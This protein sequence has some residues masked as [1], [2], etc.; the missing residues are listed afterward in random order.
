MKKFLF[1]AMACVVA[2]VANVN[3]QESTETLDEVVVKTNPF[4]TNWFIQAGVGL[5]YFEGDFA[6]DINLG[7]KISPNV[8]LEIG[9]WF[10]P[11]VGLRAG[12]RGYELTT[13]SSQK[14]EFSSSSTDNEGRFTETYEVSNLHVDFLLNLSSVICG[15]KEDHFYKCVPYVGFGVMQ[16]YSGYWDNDLAVSAGLLNSF[17]L[18][19]AFDLNLDIAYTSFANEYSFMGRTS[20]Y[21]L[22]ATVGLTY[23]FKKRGWEG[24]KATFTGISEDDFARINDQLAAEKAKNSA[25]E[26]DLNDQKVLTSAAAA[27]AAAAEAKAAA[28]EAKIVDPNAQLLVTFAIAATKL[29][30]LSLVNIEYYANTIKESNDGDEFVLTGYADKKTGSESINDRL[31]KERAEVVYNKLVNDFGV[32]PAKL[33]IEYK[34]GVDNMFYDDATLS[35]SVILQPAK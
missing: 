31:S 5:V 33:S 24:C 7:D 20:D 32:D 35:R 23:K 29:D 8:N 28:A 10:T 18:S 27:E 4:L 19:P 14:T 15:Y 13:L 26:N 6:R 12:I 22:G 1:L 34:G 30:N 2:S 16:R 9:K 17:Y 11:S 25:L 3:A 21:T